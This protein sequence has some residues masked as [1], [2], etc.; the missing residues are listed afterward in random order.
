[1]TREKRLTVLLCPLPV[2]GVIK[3]LH[4]IVTEDAIGEVGLELL[5]G[6]LPVI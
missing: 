5:H 1:M 6:Q 3:L 2:D 4:L